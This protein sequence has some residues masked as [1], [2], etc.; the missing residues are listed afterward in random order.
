VRLVY[1]ADM[2]GIELGQLF[3]RRRH[4]LQ[5]DGETA[6]YVATLIGLVSARIPELDRVVGTLAPAWPVAQMA[7]V[8]VAILRLAIAEIDAA[9]VPPAVVINEAVE[10][11]KAYGADNAWRLVNGALGAYVR[12]SPPPPQP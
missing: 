4:E 2:A 6:A 7:R 10:L 3:A 5:V 8:D 1:E 9:Q 12:R 11:A